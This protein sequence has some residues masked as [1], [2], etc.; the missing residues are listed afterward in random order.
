MM[1]Y[2]SLV[3]GLL[4][5]IA[6]L[7]A[8]Q[9]AAFERAARLAAEPPPA[10]LRDHRDRSAGD[11]PHA[12][13]VIS[14]S[15]A[16]DDPLLVLGLGQDDRPIAIDELPIEGPWPDAVLAR[17]QHATPGTYFE[18]GISAPAGVRRVLVLVTS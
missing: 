14:H 7:V 10:A 3:V 6:L 12:I 16:G 9:G 17:W 13:V 4:A 1:I 18:L 5:A 15:G 2:R 11:A 8:E